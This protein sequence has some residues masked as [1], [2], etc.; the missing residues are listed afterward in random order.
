MNMHKLTILAAALSAVFTLSAG[1]DGNLIAEAAEF[2]PEAKPYNKANNIARWEVKG[3]EYSL[4]KSEDGI[5]CI[6]AKSPAGKQ[7]WFKTAVNNPGKGKYVFSVR[8]WTEKPLKRISLFRFSYGPDKKYVYQNKIFAG[9]DLPGAK[10]WKTL[11]VTLDFP[12]DTKRF[13]LIAQ[14]HDDS[15]FRI[16]FAEPALRKLED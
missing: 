4:R 7:H 12:A 10:Q 13:N 3:M 14:I 8:I 15:D 11:M 2:K 1:D 5:K 16:L 6:E 9:K